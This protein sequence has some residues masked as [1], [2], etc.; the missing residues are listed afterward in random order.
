MLFLLENN[1]EFDRNPKEYWN[2]WL[3]YKQAKE[4]YIKEVADEYKSK[5]PQFPQKLYE[6]MHNYKIEIDD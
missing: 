4:Q 6:A 2:D 1:A 5:Y 3:T